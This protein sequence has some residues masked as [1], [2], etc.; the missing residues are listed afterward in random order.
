MDYLR[1][2]DSIDAP[3]TSVEV[4]V[5]LKTVSSATLTRLVEEVRNN[6]L[7]MGRYD[8]THNRHNR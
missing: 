4:E 1:S 2:E 5:D 3:N 7:A 6:E 8:R